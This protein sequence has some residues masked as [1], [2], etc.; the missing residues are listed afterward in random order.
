MLISYYASN[1]PKS[2][3]GYGG[4]VGGGGCKPILVYAWVKLNNYFLLVFN[5]LEHKTQIIIHYFS[6]LRQFIMFSIE[7]ELNESQPH[8]LWRAVPS[9]AHAEDYIVRYC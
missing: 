1:T 3:C 6:I 5:V 7:D 2:L 4:A 9:S 8:K